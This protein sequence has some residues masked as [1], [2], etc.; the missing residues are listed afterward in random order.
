M[1]E[2]KQEAYKNTI[3]LVAFIIFVLRRCRFVICGVVI[4]IIAGFLLNKAI[5][6]PTYTCEARYYLT[7]SEDIV[8]Y[9]ALQATT[10]IMQDYLA[11]IKSKS[12]VK[13]AIDREGL[14]VNIDD[15]L[16]LISVSN[17]EETR[18]LIVTVR[19]Q[20]QHMAESLMNGISYQ[21]LNY[22]PI[23]MEGSSLYVFENVNTSL[24][25]GIKKQILNIVLSTIV[26]AGIAVLILLIQFMTKTAVEDPEEV[27]RVT[28]GTRTYLF[29]SEK[30]RFVLRSDKK[31]KALEKSLNTAAT[32]IVYDL[33]LATKRS[34]TI[35]VTSIDEGKGGVFVARKL[36]DSLCKAG[37]D[38]LL[39]DRDLTQLQEISSNQKELTEKS[40]ALVMEQRGDL[41]AAFD[42]LK[43]SH[44]F[45]IIDSEPV[46]QNVEPLVLARHCDKV[47][48]TAKYGHTSMQ[49]LEKGIQRFRDN[50][51][52]VHAVVLNM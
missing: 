4:G 28:G 23:I 7:V 11:M 17:P 34:G 25:D 45:I 16:E 3:D 24:D 15:A 2:K 32:E 42:S 29:P 40:S 18:L 35:L 38:V 12:I 30:K 9:G 48:M 46:L 51:L 5:V 22:L 13:R 39:V 14:I 36:Y 47:V 31:Q 33:T 10:T 43:A 20:D 1:G 41:S 49:D 27:T 44:D 8:S 50:N 26:F 21:I 52:T 6:N 37:G 19:S